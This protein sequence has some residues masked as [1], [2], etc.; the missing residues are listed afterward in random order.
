MKR[1]FLIAPRIFHPT[2]HLQSRVA[3]SGQRRGGGMQAVVFGSAF[4]LFATAAS[5]QSSIWKVTHGE[6]SLY[7]G[8]TVHLLRK[9]DFPLPVEFDV[10]V[11]AAEEIW[12][13]VDF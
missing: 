3:R 10:A 13:E 11:A 2:S 5:A 1:R 8:G 7:V 6:D 9:S 4:A 12:F